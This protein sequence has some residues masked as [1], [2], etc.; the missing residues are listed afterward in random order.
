MKGERFG[1]GSDP[2][3]QEDREIPDK[4][5]MKDFLRS[6]PYGSGDTTVQWAQRE[7]LKKVMDKVDLD[8]ETTLAMRHPLVDGINNEVAALASK[9]ELSER[10]FADSEYGLHPEVQKTVDNIVARIARVTK[11]RTT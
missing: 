11:K 1:R 8:G 6:V 4:M 5:S 7:I 10:L 9:F 3:F 2:T